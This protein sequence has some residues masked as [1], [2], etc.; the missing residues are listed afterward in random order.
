MENI[1]PILL[2]AKLTDNDKYEKL[3][4]GNGSGLIEDIWVNELGCEHND[5]IYGTM[6]YLSIFQNEGVHPTDEILEERE[7]I[8][9]Y[10][11]KSFLYE[12]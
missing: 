11:N 2:A 7:R 9:R 1:F 8:L 6:V 12:S 3:V 5:H 4:S 10:L